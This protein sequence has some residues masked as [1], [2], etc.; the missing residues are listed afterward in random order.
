MAER[1]FN[2]ALLDKSPAIILT[3]N[4]K[5]EIESCSEAWV[6][7]MG[8]SREEP[9]GKSFL[10]FF[11]PEQQDAVRKARERFRTGFDKVKEFNAQIMAKSG[12]VVDFVLNARVENSAAHWRVILTI[13]DVTDLMETQHKLTELVEHDELT[14]P[15]SRRGLKERFGKGKRSRAA[16]LFLLDVDHFKSVNDTYG[17][18]AGD[19]L[20]QAFGATLSKLTQEEGCAVRLGGEEFTL[21]RP[22]KGWDEAQGLRH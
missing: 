17:H 16:G 6:E 13:S 21:L 1:S 8:Y 12:R 19:R 9:L 14:G 15:L 20:L 10:D 11:V 3:E 18:E 5:W 7:K 2:E 4:R 22:W